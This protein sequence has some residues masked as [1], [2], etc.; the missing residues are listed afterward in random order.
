[1]T[2]TICKQVPS[3]ICRDVKKQKCENVPVVTCKWGNFYNDASSAIRLP[4]HFNMVVYRKKPNTKCSSIPHRVCELVTMIPN[5]SAVAIPLKTGEG[6]CMFH[7]TPWDL[8]PSA[9]EQV[10]KVAGDQVQV[11]VFKCFRDLIS[12]HFPRQEPSSN[13]N[14]FTQN[15]CT[16]V[17]DF[18]SS[19]LKF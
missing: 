9:Y 4:I 5:V 1:M 15:V 2:D 8:P 11:A 7:H 6:L 18:I 14:K 3:A 16:T 10:W 17:G 12:K 19:L 13:C